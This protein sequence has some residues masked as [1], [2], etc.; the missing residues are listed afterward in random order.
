MFIFSPLEQFQIIP[1]IQLRYFFGEFSITNAT[2]IIFLSIFALACFMFKSRSYTVRVFALFNPTDTAELSSY[3]IAGRTW[4]T[5]FG[6][7]FRR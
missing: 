4:S 7:P 1:V 3:A 2:V 5:L 6:F